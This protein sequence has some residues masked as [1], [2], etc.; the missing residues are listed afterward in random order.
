MSGEG[1][2]VK[3]GTDCGCVQGAG[4]FGVFSPAGPAAGEAPGGGAT[5]NFTDHGGLIL[6][7]VHVHLIFWGT[8]WGTGATPSVGAVSD[9][10]INM[11]SGPYMSAL[12]QYR[13]AGK[14]TLTGITIVSSG[15]G[16]SPANPP[17]PFSN[18]NVET[19]ISNLLT[20]QRVPSPA[21][22]GQLLYVVITPPGVSS[23]QANVIGEHTFFGL[24]GRNAHYA[25]ITNNGTLANVTV[26]FSHELVES[27]TDPEGSAILGDPGTC[28][29]GGWCEIGDVCGST[30]VINGVTVQSYWSQRDK[31]CIVPDSKYEK[32]NKDTK[33]HKDSKDKE[34]KDHKDSKDNKEH[35]EIKDG[36]KEAKE[37]PKEKE[38]A[39]DI[40]A[41]ATSLAD[42]V[43]RLD[44]LTQRVDDLAAK[45]G[46]GGGKAFIR[47]EERP[48]VGQQAL[49][50]PKQ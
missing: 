40:E 20:A 49:K 14:G 19:L 50:E 8:A 38:A 31:A 37:A 27:V 25:W 12:N 2:V 7:H 39:K 11:M 4:H 47:G 13:G 46:Q 10:V 1:G 17:N 5:I 28:N 23:N 3:N 33:D 43:Q 6:D 45:M 44:T 9:A 41:P 21:T 29:Q 36:A 48:P 34:Q 26:I 15:V 30:G 35:K 24:A 32:D 18:G 16:S 22:D 42:V